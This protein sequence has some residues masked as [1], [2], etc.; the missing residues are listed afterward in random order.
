M[1]RDIE[2]LSK[3]IE[4][5]TGNVQKEVLGLKSQVG[6]ISTK[7]EERIQEELTKRNIVTEETSHEIEEHMEKLKELEKKLQAIEGKFIDEDNKI[8]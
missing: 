5:L 3:Q 4:S 7:N 8:I 6:T 2:D 1:E